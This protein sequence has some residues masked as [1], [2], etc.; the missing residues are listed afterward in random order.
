VAQGEGAEFKPQYLKKKKE[1]SQDLIVRSQSWNSM[2]LSFISYM[3]RG[4]EEVYF[5]Q[6]NGQ[7]Q[8]KCVYK[9]VT[10]GS[11]V[12]DFQKH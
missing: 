5:D 8:A 9:R 10:I 7:L 3:V 1:F 11:Y 12:P 6:E 2:K 4:K